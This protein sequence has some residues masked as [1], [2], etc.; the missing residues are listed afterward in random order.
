[1]HYKWHIHVIKRIKNTWDCSFYARFNSRNNPVNITREQMLL[2]KNMVY[3]IFSLCDCYICDYNYEAWRF[4]WIRYSLWNE[5]IKTNHL[6][7]FFFMLLEELHQH[8]WQAYNYT[9]ELYY[10]KWELLKFHLIL[11][12][13]LSFVLVAYIK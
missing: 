11:M 10:M 13:F 8:L 2:K 3:C 6:R 12:I 7:C 9:I 4:I 1:M 5:T